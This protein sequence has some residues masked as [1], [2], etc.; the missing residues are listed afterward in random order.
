[1]LENIK[2]NY[3]SVSVYIIAI[4]CVYLKEKIA[5]IIQCTFLPF[6]SVVSA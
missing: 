4:I 6:Y 1:M 2:I 3:N 5:L